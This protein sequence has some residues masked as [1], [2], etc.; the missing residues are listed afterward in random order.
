[1]EQFWRDVTHSVRA[2]LKTPGFTLT[3]LAALALGIGANTAVFSV[4]NTVLLRPVPFPNPDRLVIFMN[5]SP[6]GSGSNASPA[7]FDLWRRQTGAFQDVSAFRANVANLTGV[8]EPEQIPVGQ[9]SADFFT[10]FGAPIAR[11]RTFSADEDL[12]NGG[13]VAV[14]SYG[15]WQR[16]FGGRDDVIGQTLSLDN[17]PHVIIGVVGAGFRADGLNTYSS[18]APD[19]W[20]PFQLDPNSATQ[21]HYFIAGGKLRPGVSIEQA[22]AQIQLVAGEFRRTYPDA[23]GK[24][25]GFDVQRLRDVQVAGVRSSLLILLGAVS[26]VLL[27]ACA[28]LASLLLVRASVRAREIAIRAA[29]GAGRARIVR[30]LLTESLVLAL[31]GGAC[32]LVLGLVGIRA[33][34]AFNP[35]NIPRI[36]ASGANVTLDWRLALFTLA[37]STATGLIFGL[38]PALQASRANL[39]LALKEAGGRS[40]TGFRQNKARAILVV[41]EVALA[42]VL[43][44]GAALLIRTFVALRTVDPGFDVHHV[45]V[46]RMSLS[47]PR[48]AQTAGVA[49]LIRDGVERMRAVPGVETAAATCCVPLAGGYGLPFVIAGRPLTDGPFHGGGSWYTISPDYFSAFKIPILR[50]RA[51]TERDAAGTSGVVIINQAMAQQYWMDRDPI[52]ERI[53][54]GGRLVGPEFE[55]PP[56]QIVG[57]VGDVRDGGLNR[58]PG[59]SMY[60]PFAQVSDALNALNVGI[61][62][63]TWVART[64]TEPYSVNVPIQKELRQASSGLAL[65]RVQSMEEVVAQ[66]T[67]RSQ[68]NMLL[69]AVFGGAALALAAIGVYGLMAYA[70]QQRTQEIGIR[71]ALGAD[72]SQVRNLVVFQGM[73]L[74]LIGVAVGLLS[75]FGVSRILASLLFGVTASD[76]VVF[77]SVAAILLAV[78]L[79]AV[80]V[81]ARR[82]GRVDPLLALRRD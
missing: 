27:I 65:A 19:V 26:L 46:M 58:N 73:R 3:A 7:K 32:G 67:S 9:V 16:R 24:Q 36:G 53:T 71:R 70:V 38:A 56:R 29:I 57:I 39:N 49:Q 13:H 74:S 78:A 43:V 8:D 14:V 37:I 2:F 64:R 80:W 20:V 61:T 51:F 52:G 42:L 76:P 66:A 47:G 5:T 63:L 28:N 75:A 54:V 50:G 59:P 30:Q 81:P 11:G 22:K 17:Q 4:V 18:A 31:A 10:L 69:L 34:L 62:P 72:S 23:L 40:G 41:G 25:A 45:L 21:G 33:L 77:A 6:Q 35:G 15:F 60:V 55:E 48:F 79:A 1:M 44:V 12:P 68:F 82:A